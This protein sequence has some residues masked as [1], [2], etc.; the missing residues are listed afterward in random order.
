ME[1]FS[2]NF[3]SKVEVVDGFN[4]AQ[5]I[6]TIPTIDTMSEDLLRDDSTR[7]G[8]GED[9]SEIDRIFEALKHLNE[10][11]EKRAYFKQKKKLLKVWQQDRRRKS[12]M[13]LAHELHREYKKMD[14]DDE[15]EELL[16]KQMKSTIHHLFAIIE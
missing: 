8:G 1:W 11:P 3:P 15:D 16:K 4:A 9:A 5:T 10:S 14:S 12:K 7:G 6:V 13:N 2:A